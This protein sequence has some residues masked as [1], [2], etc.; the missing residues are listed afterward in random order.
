MGKTRRNISR[1]LKTARKPRKPRKPRKQ[2]KTRKTK[3]YGKKLSS[4]RH[5]G[6]LKF[7]H[8]GAAPPSVEYG[9][10]GTSSNSPDGGHTTYGYT[11]PQRRKTWA[12]IERYVSE[13]P[14]PTSSSSAAPAL[15][16]IG[17]TGGEQKKVYYSNL[18]RTFPLD[19]RI[20]G[21]APSISDI[22]LWANYKEDDA[23]RDEPEP[24]IYDEGPNISDGDTNISDDEGV[25]V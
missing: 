6:W 22:A 21:R 4:T 11:K 10:F 13:V 8:G 3:K 5:L 19:Y 9:F 1:K 14:G 12:M 24:N 23:I 20:N 2:K 15:R 16:Q 17:W 18:A 25:W 7:F